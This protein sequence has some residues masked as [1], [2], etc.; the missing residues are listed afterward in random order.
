MPHTPD[1]FFTFIPTSLSDIFSELNSWTEEWTEKGKLKCHTPQTEEVRD[2]RNN[3]LL[4]WH[5]QKL[6]S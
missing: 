3:H 5:L 6:S 2:F 1:T 4:L